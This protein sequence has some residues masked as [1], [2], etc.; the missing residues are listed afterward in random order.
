MAIKLNSKP[1]DLANYDNLIF[2]S[3]SSNYNKFISGYN[4]FEVLNKK[5][6]F[7]NILET[8]DYD[9]SMNEIIKVTESCLRNIESSLETDKEFYTTTGLRNIKYMDLEL[10]DRYSDNVPF[11][12]IRVILLLRIFPMY[13]HIMN[14]IYYSKRCLPTNPNIDFVNPRDLP[15]QYTLI[16]EF[17]LDNPK[18]FLNNVVN[19]HNSNLQILNY[20]YRVMDDNNLLEL[21]RWRM[22]QS[23]TTPSISFG[24][25]DRLLSRDNVDALCFMVAYTTRDTQDELNSSTS[26]LLDF[27]FNKEDLERYNIEASHELFSIHKTSDKD[28]LRAL[29]T[30]LLY[31]NNNNTTLHKYDSLYD[32]RYKSHALFNYF[33][34]FGV[35]G[36]DEVGNDVNIILNLIRIHFHPTDPASFY[37]FLFAKNNSKLYNPDLYPLVVE[38]ERMLSNQVDIRRYSPIMDE[39]RTILEPL[40]INIEDMSIISPLTAM[41]GSGPEA[42]KTG[43]QP[44]SRRE[45]E[46]LRSN[47]GNVFNKDQIDRIL[48]DINPGLPQE[49]ELKNVIDDLMNHLEVQPERVYLKSLYELEEHGTEDG[50]DLKERLMNLDV[51][52]TRK[53]TMSSEYFEDVFPRDFVDKRQFE[54]IDVNSII[55]EI[56][57]ELGDSQD[58]VS[59]GVPDEVVALLCVIKAIDDIIQDK[60]ILSPKLSKDCV[61]C[62]FTNLNFNIRQCYHKN[63]RVIEENGVLV[64]LGAKAFGGEEGFGGGSNRI[65][66]NYSKLMSGS[67]GVEFGS[68]KESYL[69]R[70]LNKLDSGMTED[71]DKY[72]T[73]HRASVLASIIRIFVKGYL[74]EDV[75]RKPLEDLEET[76]VRIHYL[77]RIISKKYKNTILSLL[78]SNSRYKVI[79]CDGNKTNIE[80]ILDSSIVDSDYKIVVR[81]DAIKYSRKL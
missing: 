66:L 37:K 21:N 36:V 41:K 57:N 5:S 40:S 11:E 60:I 75:N 8:I 16:K 35:D 29:F 54:D 51:P 74:L 61:R 48:D 4:C 69:V 42:S 76:F 31:T 7:L 46:E 59:D 17:C 50:R 63:H 26:R 23:P 58:G 71:N 34:S 64:P 79:F 70:M 73:V 24:D 52:R 38:L 12:V 28:L 13:H 49:T 22:P 27:K 45:I 18:Y 6:G 9:Y 33:N 25:V 39:I 72:F 1:M 62:I 53:R 10:I 65:Y 32:G 19:F 2:D 55:R 68:F 56:E 44:L 80:A 30:L 78:L 81:D 43:G 15:P 67:T 14:L 47:L 3:I 77:N 20:H